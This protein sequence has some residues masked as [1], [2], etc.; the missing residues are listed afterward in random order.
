MKSLI[1]QPRKEFSIQWE[2]KHCL[3]PWS[4]KMFVKVNN[5]EN[6]T[7]EMTLYFF[8][9]EIFR[10]A[11]HTFVRDYLTPYV[12]HTHTHDEVDMMMIV[13][14]CCFVYELT[15]SHFFCCYGITKK[16]REEFLFLVFAGSSSLALF[17][18]LQKTFLVWKHL[19]TYEEIVSSLFE[20]WSH[21]HVTRVSKS[22]HMLNASTSVVKTEK[23][24]KT[25]SCLVKKMFQI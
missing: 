25:K 14:I 16:N 18:L 19:H 6:K 15:T 21:T 9:L 4:T 22:K 11:Q 5:Y 1:T 20:K 17:L 7:Q 3:T 13:I 24:H 2:S 23:T 12:L 8:Y 10:E